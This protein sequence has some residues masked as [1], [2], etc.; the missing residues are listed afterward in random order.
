LEAKR[1]AGFQL[2]KVQNGL[3]PSD[4]K[5]M[6]NI[7]SGVQEIRIRA[8][9]GIYRIVYV[10]KFSQTVFVLHAFQKKTQKTS[11]LDLAAAIRAYKQVEEA[12]KP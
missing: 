12:Q 4:W 9:N 6:K 11:Q 10:A 7:D 3:E 5:S 2:D 8:S 1:E